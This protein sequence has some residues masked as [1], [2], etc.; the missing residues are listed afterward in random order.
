GECFAVAA[1]EIVDTGIIERVRYGIRSA[2][3]PIIQDSLR[4]VAAVIKVYTP[5][6]PSWRRYIHDGYGQRTDGGSYAGWGTGRPW[7][8]LTGE[9]GHYEIAAGRD[10]GPYLRALEPFAQG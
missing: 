8:L 1:K 2:D 5:F 7:P 6:G 4:V 3:D 10:A 9:R